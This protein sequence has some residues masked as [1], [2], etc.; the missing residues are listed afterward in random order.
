MPNND[1][2]NAA[3]TNSAAPAQNDD[4]VAPVSDTPAEPQIEPEPIRDNPVESVKD[5][6]GNVEKK[7]AEKIEAS[8]NILV[9]LSSDPNVDE[10]SAAIGLT[11]ILN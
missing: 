8:N 7:V 5:R 2:N 3:V 11:M 9:A 4:A 10:I 6:L 1:D